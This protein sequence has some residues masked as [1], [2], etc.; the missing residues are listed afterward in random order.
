MRAEPS[1]RGRDG[2]PENPQKKVGRTLQV[3]G[4]GF[5]RTGT[6]SLKLALETL[7][8]GPCYHMFE[9]FDHPGHDLLWE[10]MAEG[11]GGDWEEIFAGFHSAVDWPVAAFYEPLM[12]RYPDAKVVLTVRDPEAWYESAKRTIAPSPEDTRSG[13]GSRMPR[14]VI[15]DGVFGGRFHDKAHALAVFERHAAEVKERVPAG[16]LL[17]YDPSD[18]WGPLCR[19]LGVDVPTQPYPHRNTTEQFLERQEQRRPAP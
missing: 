13:T 17:V 1:R 3:I 6:F 8:F 18:G 19:F 15:W 10:A 7:G 4:A 11:R 2:T 5:G 9:V 14:L 16:R 12:R